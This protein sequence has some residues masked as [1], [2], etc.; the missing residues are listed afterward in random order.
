[1]KHQRCPNTNCGY[2]GFGKPSGQHGH[3]MTWP[4]S[5]TG[6]S[7]QVIVNQ[8]QVIFHDELNPAAKIAKW[9]CLKIGEKNPS[10]GHWGQWW[11]INKGRQTRVWTDEST[12]KHEDSTLKSAMSGAMF[13]PD[14]R[15]FWMGIQ[16]LIY[17]IIMFFQLPWQYVRHILKLSR[18]WIQICRQISA[19][20]RSLT[21]TARCSSRSTRLIYSLLRFPKNIRQCSYWFAN[22]T[23]FTSPTAQRMQGF[24]QKQTHTEK[25][26]TRANKKNHREKQLRNTVFIVVFLFLV[27]LFLMRLCCFS[28]FAKIKFLCSRWPHK[29]N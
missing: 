10:N 9:V 21:A 13:N 24:T 23:N 15:G 4:M 16:T 2:R 22:G 18:T 3:D 7:P 29:T 6:E 25:H 8:R 12:C 27:N 26:K 1:M 17:A 19:K 11:M 14:S 20:T 5:N 28:C